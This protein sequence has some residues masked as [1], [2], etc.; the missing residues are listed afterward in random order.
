MAWVLII[1]GLLLVFALF[2]GVSMLETFTFKRQYEQRN[3]TQ[4]DDMENAQ[5]AMSEE[6]AKDTNKVANF[7]IKLFSK[8]KK[9]KKDK[10][11]HSHSDD[12]SDL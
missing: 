7:T 8:I 5:I 12:K 1:L 4:K 10:I 6:I 2:I 9:L 3:P 11:V